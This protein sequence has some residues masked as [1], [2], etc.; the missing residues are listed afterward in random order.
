MPSPMNRKTYLTGRPLYKAVSAA[1]GATKTAIKTK[2]SD[3]TRDFQTAG[4]LIS[5][6]SSVF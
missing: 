4:N 6:I 1:T 3:K 2:A 5:V